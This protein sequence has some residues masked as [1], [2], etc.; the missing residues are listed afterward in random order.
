[1]PGWAFDAVLYALALL[2]LANVVLLARLIALSGFWSMDA[3]IAVLLVG[4]NSGYSAIVVAH[5]MIHRPSKAMQTIGRALLCTVMYEHFFTEHLRGHH[6]RVGTPEDPATARFGESFDAFWR[7]T[8]PGQFKSAWRLEA[9]RLGDENMR[10]YDPRL[11]KSRVVHGIA[12]ELALAGAIFALFG[13]GALVIF[14]LQALS[15]IR[16][17]EAVNYFEHWGLSRSGKKIATVDSWDAESWFTLYTLVGLSRHADHHAHATRPYQALRWFDDSPK[18]PRGYFGMVLM[19][20]LRN[21]RFVR[22]MTA[23]LQRKKLGP[24]AELPSHA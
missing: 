20:L 21:R 11:L 24:F 7:R 15:A 22:L 17:L 13:P 23:E 18:L 1:L 3:L 8:V 2:Q 19:V 10:L 6:A 12:A 16:L 14:L 5:E 9:K 4:T